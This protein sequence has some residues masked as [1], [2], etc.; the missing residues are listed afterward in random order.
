[1][2][3]VYIVW[4]IFHCWVFLV[5]LLVVMRLEGSCHCR[6]VQF[7]CDS[8]TPV[9]YQICYCSVCRKV[10]GA[11]GTVNLG[12]SHDS[13]EVRCGRDSIR[14]YRAI[15]DG[16]RAESQRSFCGEC[17]AMLWLWDPSWPHLLHP[18]AAAIDTPM[19]PPDRFVASCMDSKRE[20]VPV[21]AG[22][23]AYDRYGPLSIDEWHK[24]HGKYV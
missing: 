4:F 18:F 13:L 11:L 5:I 24:E 19:T 10:G 8:H 17:S 9:P 16:K 3:A 22:V 14:V 12:A 6:A 2:G 1:M 20:W 23:E 21:P 15:I 7:A